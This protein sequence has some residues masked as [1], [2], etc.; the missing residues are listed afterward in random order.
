MTLAVEPILNA[1]KVLP[2][3][4]DRCDRGHADGRPLGPVGAHELWLPVTAARSSPHATSKA[5]LVKRK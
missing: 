2:H 5:R 1:A 4:G 3:P